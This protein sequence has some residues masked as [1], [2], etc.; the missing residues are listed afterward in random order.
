MNN[1][2]NSTGTLTEL[3]QTVKDQA[4]RSADYLANT[5]NL[6]FVTESNDNGPN[7]PVIVMEAHKG[8]PTTMLRVN[9]VAFDQIALKADIPT[10][11]AR[12]LRDEYPEVLDHAIRSIWDKENEPR[13]VRA[14]MDSSGVESD[15]I[16]GTAR[17]FVSDRFKTFDNI[18][19][20]EAALPQ[21]MESD[22]QWQVVRGTVTEKQMFIELKSEV[23]TADA[24]ER[25]S[26][27]HPT[28][29][30]MSLTD[31]TRQLGGVNRTV[32]DVMALA[33][34]LRNS[35]VGLGSIQASQMLMT[36]ACLNGMQT[37]NTHRSAHLTSARGDAEFARMLKSDTIEADNHALKLKLRDLISAYADKDQFETLIDKFVM[38]R[39]DLITV[40][41]QQAVEN[42]GT[43][44]KLT[45]PQTASV[46]D[47]LM[48]TIQQDGYAGHDISRATMINA[49]TAVQHKVSPDN[50]AEWQVMGG[51][52]LDLPA[53]QWSVVANREAA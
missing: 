37:G 9:D 5:N 2:E 46:L 33:I 19:L 24:A 23:I 4:A 6:Q 26:N 51:K 53:S 42:L 40:S 34:R 11:T 8:M 48:S 49:V 30:V 7:K 22:A 41:P 39:G 43:I 35:E 12:R 32:G 31:H 50:M 52:V 20:L 10:R 18:H 47:G 28:N 15:Y 29:N 3:M 13:M 17:A 1:I 25:A 16:A 38:A 45:K 27:P 36:L 14:F 44:L 21:L